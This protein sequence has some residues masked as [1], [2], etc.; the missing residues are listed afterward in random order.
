MGQA[1]KENINAKE[2]AEVIMGS[3]CQSLSEK[4]ILGEK[5]RLLIKLSKGTE[6]VIFE[7]PINTKTKDE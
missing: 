3:I 5:F 2:A 4:L 1:R 7:Q 6:E